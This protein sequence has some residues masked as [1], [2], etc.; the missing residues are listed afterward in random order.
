VLVNDFAPVH[1]DPAAIAA[2]AR[3]EAAALA[4]R[5]GI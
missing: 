5:A 4:S 2:E 1:L 3:T